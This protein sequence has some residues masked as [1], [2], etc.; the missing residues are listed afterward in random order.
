M[1][2]IYPA[3]LEVLLTTMT[4]FVSDSYGRRCIKEY[5]K[6]TNFLSE[7]EHEMH[8]SLHHEPTYI[9]F[10]LCLMRP[11]MQYAPTWQPL[12]Q[13]LETCFA[14]NKIPFPDV[15]QQQEEQQNNM[16]KTTT[17]AAAATTTDYSNIDY[18]PCRDIIETVDKRGRLELLDMFEMEPFQS[19]Q[20]PQVLA[21]YKREIDQN[22]RTHKYLNCV[23]FPEH[24]KCSTL[25][26]NM[27]APIA[28]CACEE[29]FK[30]STECFQK[31]Q[32]MEEKP[33]WKHLFL[34]E[35]RLTRQAHKNH[36]D[37]VQRDLVNCAEKYF[38]LGVIAYD[39]ERNL[40]LIDPDFRRK[41]QRHEWGAVT[42]KQRQ[43]E[44]D[45]LRKEQEHMNALYSKY[46]KQQQE[47]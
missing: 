30:A 32:K 39:M 7:H 40:E 19:S 9:N 31:N 37:N 41:I 18:S 46:K 16:N 45:K 33:L 36:C 2:I 47:E 1:Q 13:K 12:R 20:I 25:R 23:A 35:D 26:S 10:Q 24:A 29:I 3:T 17:T 5:R 11:L 22:E 4:D 15:T 6:L 43:E 28:G 27:F 21:A 42:V 44:E 34:S 38:R 14:K 8:R